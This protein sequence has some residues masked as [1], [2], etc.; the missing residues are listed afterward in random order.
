MNEMLN[1]IRTLIVEER[2][3]ADRANAPRFASPHEAYGVIMEEMMEAEAEYAAL[4]DNSK[5][6]MIKIHANSAN[7]YATTLK[8]MQECAYNAVAELVQ[9]A[10]MCGKALDSMEVEEIG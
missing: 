5:R 6:L 2:V 9:V 1:S 8:R 10:A 4:M 7:G 3:R